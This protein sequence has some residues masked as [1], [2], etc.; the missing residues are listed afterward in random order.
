M[1]LLQKT[2][3]NLAEFFLN[4]LSEKINI[5]CT[6][7]INPKSLTLASGGG[8]EKKGFVNMLLSERKLNSVYTSVLQ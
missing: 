4:V 6:L 7:G 3:K 1:V 5:G 2:N 8:V